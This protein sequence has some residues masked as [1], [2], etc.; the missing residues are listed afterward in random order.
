MAVACLFQASK[1]QRAWEDGN[2]G[3][4]MGSLLIK[5]T[6]E[7]CDNWMAGKQRRL[8]FPKTVMYHAGE[9]LELVHGD[10]CGPM[11]PR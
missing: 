5:H 7:L 6:S 10:L 3:Q 4:C 2:G 8:P 11:T 1:L 9:L